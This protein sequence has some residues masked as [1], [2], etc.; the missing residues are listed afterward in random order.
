MQNTRKRK[1]AKTS[2]FK[3]VSLH[4]QLGRWV[5]QIGINSKTVY[6]GLFDNEEDAA[7]AYDAKAREVFGQFALTNFKEE[8]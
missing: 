4:S 8:G 1:D 7:R 2:K 6:I 3:G 5:A